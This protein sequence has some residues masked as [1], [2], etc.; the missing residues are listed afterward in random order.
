MKQVHPVAIDKMDM[1]DI[2]NLGNF[3]DKHICVSCD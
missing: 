3:F 1:N 2:M